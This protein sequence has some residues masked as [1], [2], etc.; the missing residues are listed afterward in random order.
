M[1]EEGASRSRP[2]GQRLV[3]LLMMLCGALS[4]V[5]AT[6]NDGDTPP[7]RSTGGGVEVLGRVLDQSGSVEPPAEGSAA[8]PAAVP[9]AVSGA[10]DPPPTADPGTD[11]ALEPAP[12]ST[13]PR[14]TRAEGA[15]STTTTRALAEPI[16]NEPIDLRV[17]VSPVAPS[18]G[19][20]VTITVTAADPDALLRPPIVCVTADGGGPV[21]GFDGGEAATSSCTEP[22]RCGERGADGSGTPVSSEGRWSMDVEVIGPHTYTVEVFIASGPRGCDPHLYASEAEVTRTV[23]VAG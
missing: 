10:A 6:R 21:M 15:T 8:A 14:P 7:A 1:R 17:E 12:T 19:D 3:G 2:G 9:G 20:R 4:I 18:S 11:P 23:A 5:V 22:E 16:R 13:A